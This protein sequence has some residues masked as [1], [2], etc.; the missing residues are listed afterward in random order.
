MLLHWIAELSDRLVPENVKVVRA[1]VRLPG[2]NRLDTKRWE[3]IHEQKEPLSRD[4]V[5]RVCLFR[6]IHEAAAANY[7][8]AASALQKEMAKRM[9]ERTDSYRLYGGNLESA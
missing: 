7:L 3:Q 5:D 1:C 8:P 6:R 4:D 9:K 2:E